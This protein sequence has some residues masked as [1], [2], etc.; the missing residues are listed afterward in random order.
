MGYDLINLDNRREKMFKISKE[1]VEFT[2]ESMKNWQ[3]EL[4]DG[5]NY[6]RR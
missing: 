4:D 1:V 5:K 3:M 6:G 2:T